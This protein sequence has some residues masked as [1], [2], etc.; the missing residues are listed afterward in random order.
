MIEFLFYGFFTV[1]LIYLIV[2]YYYDWKYKKRIR[3]IKKAFNDCIFGEVIRSDNDFIQYV[4]RYYDESL[5]FLISKFN[6]WNDKFWSNEINITVIKR[7]GEIHLKLMKSTLSEPMWYIFNLR[8]H[9]N[10]LENE[11]YNKLYPTKNDN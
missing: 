3:I 1:G 2:D 8:V 11:C 6:P 4:Y 9:P 10:F 5:R 7:E